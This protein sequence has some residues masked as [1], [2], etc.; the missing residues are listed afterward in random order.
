M[1]ATVDY[2]LALYA[3]VGKLHDFATAAEKYPFRSP[4]HGRVIAKYTGL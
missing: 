4:R 2:I 3:I 1:G